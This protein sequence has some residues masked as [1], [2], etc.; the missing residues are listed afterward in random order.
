ML[1][2]GEN[3]SLPVGEPL[4]FG[5]L[6]AENDGLD[7]LQ[8]DIVDVKE[9]HIFLQIDEA[10][11][12]EVVDT[13]SHHREIVVD[14]QAD[15]N[16]LGVFEKFA[17]RFRYA[18]DVEAEK[19]AVVV[20]GLLHERHIVHVSA[21]ERGTSLGIESHYPCPCEFAEGDAGHLGRIYECDLTGILHH[22]HLGD[23][24][25]ADGYCLGKGVH[26]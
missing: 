23:R 26:R 11:R 9:L 6:F 4:V 5:N 10:L 8:R 21:M 13:T 3:G 20:G 12:V 17:E 24:L 18:E 15:L 1:L 19:E 2:L 16:Y 25:L 22:G 14:R 7:L